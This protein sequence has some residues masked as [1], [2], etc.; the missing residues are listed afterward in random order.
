MGLVETAVEKPLLA[1]VYNNCST[2]YPGNKI[3]YKSDSL[4]TQCQA[5]VP[6]KVILSHL[7][8][9]PLFLT[10]ALLCFFI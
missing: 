5:V 4:K 8:K 10:N 6:A 3:S 9:V 2:L 1:F 7:I